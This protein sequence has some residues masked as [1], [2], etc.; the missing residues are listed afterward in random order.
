ME[1]FFTRFFLPVYQHLGGTW[2]PVVVFGVYAIYHL[3]LR[4][5]IRH[6]GGDW[7]ELWP[8]VPLTFLFFL[9]PLLAGIQYLY[10]TPVK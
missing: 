7:N 10:F 3:L 5:F 8:L 2:S 1:A 6:E 4:A 9:I